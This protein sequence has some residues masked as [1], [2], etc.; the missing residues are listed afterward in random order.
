[1]RIVSGF[2]RIVIVRRTR[3]AQ[4]F[5]S[6]VIVM[7]AL[8]KLVVTCIA[9]IAA[10]LVTP[11]LV[12]A[13]SK[14]IITYIDR[15]DIGT[16][17]PNRM[18]WAQDIR[19]GQAIYEGLYSIDPVSF[20]PMLAVADKVNVSDDKKTWSFHLRENAKWSNG[21]AVTTADFV[22]AWRR[23]LEE[24]GDYT[25][26]LDQYIA[27][28]KEYEDAFA[29]Y[30]A[31][32]TAGQ[33]ATKPDF[34]PVAIDVPDANNLKITLKNPCDFYP[35]LLAFECYYPLNEKSME[36]FREVDSKSDRVSYK[37]EFATAGKLVCDGPYVVNWW[38]LRKGLKLTPNPYYWDQANV[39]NGGVEM[40]VAG[41]MLTQVRL[42]DEHKAD[43]LTELTGEM[44]ANM[45]DAGRKEIHI[46]PSFGTY[47]YT[48]L[49][50]EKLPDGSK[51]P[52]ADVRVRQALSMAIDKEPI[53]KN[54]TKAGEP[55]TNVYVPTGVFAAY[56]TPTG[57]KFDIKKARELM[58]EA[59]YPAGRNFPQV[60]LTFNTEGGE[61]KAVAEYIRNQWKRNLNIDIQ[62]DG[63]EIKQFQTLLHGKT[64]AVAR[65]SWY[66]DYMDVSTFTDK[67]V[68]HG[69]NNDSDWNNAE[70]DALLK[71]ATSETDAQ[72]RLDKLAAAEQILVTD[73]PI[74]P[75]YNYV[76]KTVFRDEIKGLNGNPRNIIVFKNI[77]KG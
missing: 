54:I 58:K 50:S 76:N 71:N 57:L 42:F 27:G 2:S 63:V 56:K 47:F 10:A 43:I 32:R 49:C 34:T 62:L 75:L 17:D 16:L 68:G 18:S 33:Q 59:G 3:V 61:H 73:A 36:P 30:M 44:A 41:D 38:E 23:M 1:M 45:R 6:E 48:F 35:D 52:F 37:A 51:N 19:V 12:R 22:F 15:G 70:Y 39:K 31:K 4:G 14:P 25:Y 28:A 72:K 21:D 46:D 55:V 5:F 29:D 24:P 65:A 53:V 8:L 74:L 77:S 64:Y 13:Q 26:L 40:V 20:K 66:G 9:F 69:G 67:Y 11:A 60:K 7:N